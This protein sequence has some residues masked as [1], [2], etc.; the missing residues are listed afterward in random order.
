MIAPRS[1][2][3]QLLPTSIADAMREEHGPRVLRE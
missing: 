2:E 3:S 1:S